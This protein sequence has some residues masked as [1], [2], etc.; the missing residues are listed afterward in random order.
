MA[1]A[2]TQTHNKCKQKYYFS[3]AVARIKLL[4]FLT[5]SYLFICRLIRFSTQSWLHLIMVQTRAKEKEREFHSPFHHFNNFQRHVYHLFSIWKEFST[6][7][8]CNFD[9]VYHIFHVFFFI[10]H[11]KYLETHSKLR[12]KGENTSS[13]RY[14][15]HRCTYFKV[16][17]VLELD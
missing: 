8:F 2:N 10:N 1:K 11:P 5:Q 7:L 14:L 6:S 15:T 9:C 3:V 4:F 13:T 12:P 17:D 16:I